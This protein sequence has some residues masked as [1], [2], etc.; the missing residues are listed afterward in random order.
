M[1]IYRQIRVEVRSNRA[2]QDVPAGGLGLEQGK[3][4]FIVPLLCSRFAVYW[5]QK[6]G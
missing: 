6:Y 1:T 3:Q 5:K 2:L 4:E